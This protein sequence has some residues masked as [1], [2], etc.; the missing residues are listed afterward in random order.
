VIVSEISY[1]EYNPDVPQKH[2]T[3]TTELDDKNDP[4]ADDS[5][6]GKLNDLTKDVFDYLYS[7][8]SMVLCL[9]YLIYILRI[10]IILQ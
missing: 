9:I 8:K 6:L 2:I 5:R 4:T 10:Q 7:S 1:G 3:C